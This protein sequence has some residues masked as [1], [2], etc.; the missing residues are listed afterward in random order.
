MINVVP[1]TCHEY[2]AIIE[3]IC[4]Q[5]QVGVR[6]GVQVRPKFESE[7]MSRSSLSPNRHR[8]IRSTQ[9]HR[10]GDY[11]CKIFILGHQKVWYKDDI[12]DRVG[13]ES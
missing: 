10:Y 8:K 11:T 2:E 13:H 4:V 3:I 6:F 1:R 7:S 5:V 9:I 12:F